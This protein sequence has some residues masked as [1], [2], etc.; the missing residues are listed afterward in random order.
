MKTD[1]YI[2]FIPYLLK[3]CRL[4]EID[5]TVGR[6]YGPLCPSGEIRSRIV[7]SDSIIPGDIDRCP[8]DESSDFLDN[9]GEVGALPTLFFRPFTLTLLPPPPPKD[10][11]PR[12]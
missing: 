10:D 11:E 9:E 5:E 6:L 8:V 2:L 1:L 4:R 3:A 12:G 7:S